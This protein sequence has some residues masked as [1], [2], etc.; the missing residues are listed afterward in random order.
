MRWHNFTHKLDIFVNRRV[1][2]LMFC[3]NFDNRCFSRLEGLG[4][5]TE[6]NTKDS[7]FWL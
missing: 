4:F 7:F 6:D 1:E 5:F 3:P 2:E